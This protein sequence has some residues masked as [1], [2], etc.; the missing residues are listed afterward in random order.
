MTPTE[1][2]LLAVY[3]GPLVEL[4]RICD[5]YLGLNATNANRRAALKQLP[6][7]AFRA[8]GSRKAPYLV[9]V[10]DLAAHIDSAHQA[11]RQAWTHSQL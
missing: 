4:D 6:F 8:R 11:E 1:M 10:T 9:H 3:K 2:M 7:P 5:R